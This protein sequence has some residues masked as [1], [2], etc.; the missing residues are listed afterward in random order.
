MT[1]TLPATNRQSPVAGVASHTLAEHA[2]CPLDGDA[3]LQPGTLHTYHY[4]YTDK[5]RNRKS[6]TADVTCP[7]GLSANDELYLY[8]LLALT[9]SQPEPSIDF[10]ATPH[11]CLRQL[12]FVDAHNQQQ[13][14]YDVFREAIRRLAGVVY[15]NDHFYDPVRGEHR[16]VAFGFLKY[17][18]PVD[19]GRNAV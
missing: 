16:D 6:A 1:A 8:G 14:R 3:S 4:A 9:F 19:P 2:L 10:Y 15:E 18:L 17:S 13:R 11:W 5:N 7:F 12:G